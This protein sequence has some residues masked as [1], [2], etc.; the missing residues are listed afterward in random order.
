MS[1]AHVFG[2]TSMSGPVMQN[3]Q[4]QNVFFAGHTVY[5]RTVLPLPAAAADVICSEPSCGN[6]DEAAP[7]SLPCWRALLARTYSLL[8]GGAVGVAWKPD[9]AASEPGIRLFDRCLV[10]TAR[11]PKSQ[12]PS[13]APRCRP[14]R[15]RQR[16]CSMFSML[17]MMYMCMYSST[18]Q[19]WGWPVGWADGLTPA[20]ARR[21]QPR[22]RSTHNR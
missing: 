21:R 7:P 1:H 18:S 22:R 4:Q 6:E 11:Q 10:G 15:G 5:A 9:R 3:P 16:I 2:P 12:A 14:G 20:R 13:M 8:G 17:Y 19:T